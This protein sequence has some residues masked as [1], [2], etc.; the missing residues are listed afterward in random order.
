MSHLDGPN[1]RFSEILNSSN[2]CFFIVTD[3]LIIRTSRSIN[4]FYLFE[5]IGNLPYYILYELLKGFDHLLT[6]KAQISLCIH[7]I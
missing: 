1:L 6:V 5:L 7:S 3:F 2:N 4:F